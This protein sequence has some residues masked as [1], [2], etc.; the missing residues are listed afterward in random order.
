MKGNNML[1]L[2]TATIIEAVQEYLDKRLTS[3]AR[4]RV[5]DVSP[6]SS[7]VSTTYVVRVTDE[8]EPQS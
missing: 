3:D 6:D 7:Y 1:T 8:Q 2:N 5:T 4:V